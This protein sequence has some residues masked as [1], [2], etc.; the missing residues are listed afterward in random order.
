LAF[1]DGDSE[2]TG[3]QEGKEIPMAQEQ[4]EVRGVNWNE[5]FSF[6]QIFKCFRMAIHPSKLALATMALVTVLLTVLV[7]DLLWGA[8][9]QYVQPQEIAAHATMSPAQFDRLESQWEKAQVDRAAALKADSAGQRQTLAR[10]QVL[11]AQAADERGIDPAP[12]RQTIR[13]AAEARTVSQVDLQRRDSAS[14]LLDEA[15]DLFDEEADAIERIIDDAKGDAE[16]AARQAL[17]LRRLEFRQAYLAV[18]GQRV[19]EGFISYQRNC[20]VGAV[21]AVGNLN[22][23]GNLSRYNDL[24]QRRMPGPVA[25]DPLAL[26]IPSLD[27]PGGRQL[28]QMPALPAQTDNRG[29]GLAIW[30]LLSYRGFVW[31]IAQHWVYALLFL[32]VSLATVA[33]FG[34]AVN[35]IAALHFAREEKISIVQS[36][37]FAISKFFSFFAAPLIPI[38]VIF[39]V[40]ALLVLSGLILNLPIV[41]ELIIG[42]LFFLSILGGFAIAF[43]TVGLVAGSPLMYP[44]IAV[45]GSDAFDAISRSYNYVYARPWRAII[46]GVVAAVYGVA[47]YLF[48]RLFAFLALRSTH[49][50]VKWGVWSDG[51][52]VSPAAD[53]VDVIWP[54]PTFWSFVGPFNWD[55][56]TAWRQYIGTVL[57][58]FWVL[59]VA[60]VVLAYLLTYAASAGTVIYCLLRR[61]VDA[62]DYDDV[63]VEEPQEAIEASQPAAGEQSQS[64][65][66]EAPKPEEPPASGGEAQ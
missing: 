10:Y 34:G 14:K 43:L 18:R 23:L 19:G 41:G 8:A 53:K 54:E 56:M 33:L 47:T 2:S 30:L 59:L 66:T 55:A 38:G 32:V 62:T 3:R 1:A 15:E 45:E 21:Q 52:S 61:K 9:G 64:D 7:M 58:N 51:A 31:L 17:S 36:L 28:Q 6:T 16:S 35:R 48:V 4:Q 44:T 50:F 13:Q 12:L 5:V 65:A 25:V 29:P 60:L 20:L 22:F 46:Y 57:V 11:F 24:L 37:K 49:M 63:Y 42:I 26:Q 27:G 40:G 39:A